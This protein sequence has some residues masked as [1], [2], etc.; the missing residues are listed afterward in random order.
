MWCPLSQDF[1]LHPANAY[2][3]KKIHLCILSLDPIS[4]LMDIEHH[5]KIHLINE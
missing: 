5:L 1:F 4:L 2:H 3:C